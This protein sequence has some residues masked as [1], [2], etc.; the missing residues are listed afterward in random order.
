MEQMVNEIIEAYI[1]VMGQEKWDN[2]TGEEQHTVIMTIA[3][4]LNNRI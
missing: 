1:M 4:D 3:N 2:L